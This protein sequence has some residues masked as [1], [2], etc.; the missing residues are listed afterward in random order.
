ML[1]ILGAHDA[2]MPEDLLKTV[3]SHKEIISA[4]PLRFD[5]AEAA[6]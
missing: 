1:N 2:P 3:L 5:V 6:V 4:K